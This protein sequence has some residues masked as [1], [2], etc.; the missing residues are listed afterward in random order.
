M[1]FSWL[2]ILVFGLLGYI[3]WNIFVDG[4]PIPSFF[5]RPTV[6][7]LL[8][9]FFVLLL[10]ELPNHN[11][12]LEILGYWLVLLLYALP[13]VIV[14]FILNVNVMNEYLPT[15]Q[16]FIYALIVWIVIILCIEYIQSKKLPKSAGN[17]GTQS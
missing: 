1:F 12:L 4:K 6:I 9:H 7:I 2:L 15:E 3:V 5:K 17:I 8:V 13:A 11:E 14:G 10:P 16:G